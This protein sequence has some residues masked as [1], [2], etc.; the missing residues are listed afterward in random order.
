M[1]ALE[2]LIK[3]NE[4]MVQDAVYIHCAIKSYWLV[5]PNSC[6]FGWEA[7]VVG[8]LRSGFI[9][10]FEVKVS[11]AD[12]KAEARKAHRGLLTNPMQKTFFGE[13][14]HPRPNYFYYTVPSGLIQPDEV[15]DHA[16]LLYVEKEVRSSALYYGTVK[17]AKPARRLH[18]EKL[19]DSQREQLMRAVNERYWRQR[20]GKPPKP[21]Y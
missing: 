16:G 14:R 11:R 12:F 19:A 13:R 18:S 6:V 7:D 8:V 9:S 15:P 21:V 4:R 20:L 10:E 17:I 5:V 1:A 3:W 2:Q